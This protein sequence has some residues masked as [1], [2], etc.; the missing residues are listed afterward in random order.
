M[1]QKQFVKTQ[2]I[3]YKE[4]TGSIVQNFRHKKSNRDSA[5]DQS[6]AFSV[7]HKPKPTVVLRQCFLYC[8]LSANLPFC[9]HTLALNFG[10]KSP[11]F[12]IVL[13]FLF[14]LIQRRSYQLFV[15][16][17]ML[18]L[19]DKRKLEEFMLKELEEISVLLR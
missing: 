9:Q 3:W 13:P 2:K 8:Y 1:C 6:V 16:T 19:P 7:T 11:N 5:K 14:K 12:K 10:A 15:S 18:H 17:Y 4:I